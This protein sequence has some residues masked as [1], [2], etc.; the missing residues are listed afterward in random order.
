ME[1]EKF[2]SKMTKCK[3]AHYMVISSCFFLYPLYIGFS[4]HSYN[5]SIPLL[6]SCAASVN[7]WRY[8]RYSWRRD[9]DIFFSTISCIMFSYLFIFLVKN[10]IYYTN[11]AGAYYLFRKSSHQFEEGCPH[12]WKYHLSFHLVSSWNTYIVLQHVCLSNPIPSVMI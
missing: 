6:F 1:I 9:A 3:E 5:Y 11:I 8:P 4:C 10:P 2:N 12:W 7:Y